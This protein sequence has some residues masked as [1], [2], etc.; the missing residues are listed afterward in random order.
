MSRRYTH[1]VE[2]ATVGSCT[3]QGESSG[4]AYQGLLQVST[5]HGP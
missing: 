1:H 2:S 5:E 3:V 4:G